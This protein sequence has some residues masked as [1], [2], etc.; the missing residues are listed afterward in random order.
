[1]K[2]IYCTECA[3]ILTKKDP[4][5]YICPV[6]HEF[7][8]NPRTGASVVFM[9]DGKVLVAKRKHA[10][11]QGLYG[12]PGGFLEYGEATY[13]AAIREMLEETTVRVTNM[14]LLATHTVEYDENETVCGVIYLAHA[15][16]GTFAANDDSSELEWVSIDFIDSNQFAW[17]YPGLTDKLKSIV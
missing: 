14:T 13:D 6:G 9:Q 7:F 15:W 1:M 3:Q 12:I 4:T 17:S 2:I 8:N 10:P 5:R 11:K 16:E